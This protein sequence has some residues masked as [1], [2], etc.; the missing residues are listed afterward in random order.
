MEGRFTGGTTL[1]GNVRHARLSP[2]RD[3]AA[4]R[5]RWRYRGRGRQ[6]SPA[7]PGVLTP[8]AFMNITGRQAEGLRQTGRAA[9]GEAAGEADGGCASRAGHLRHEEFYGQA[10]GIGSKASSKR[11]LPGTQ[12]GA[13]T[14][15]SPS[16]VAGRGP[17]GRGAIP[18]SLRTPS[19]G[20]WTPRRRH[21]P[22][23]PGRLRPRCAI[24]GS[25]LCPA[26]ALGA[27]SRTPPVP[28]RFRRLRWCYSAG[29]WRSSAARR[30]GGRVAG[31]G[32]RRGGARHG[33]APS[34]AG[35]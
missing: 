33:T 10:Y 32:D 28:R 35:A 3:E 22:F 4:A 31:G 12:L 13:R 21:R 27:Q 16:R 6:T 30:G 17:F 2:N 26:T 25:R 23:R 9:L 19:P 8:A 24:R 15:R 34:L 1:A 11:A 18:P 29:R 14:A 7:P 5:E 20:C